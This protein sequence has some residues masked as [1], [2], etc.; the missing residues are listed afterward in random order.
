MLGHLA[1]NILSGCLDNSLLSIYKHVW[2]GFVRV[3]LS[4]PRIQYENADKTW[5]PGQK[6]IMS[7]REPWEVESSWQP[8]NFLMLQTV[9]KYINLEENQDLRSGFFSDFNFREKEAWS[10]VTLNAESNAL[11]SVFQYCLANVSH[12]PQ[13]SYLSILNDFLFL[14]S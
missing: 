5:T 7:W 8:A 14:K 10:Q 12:I 9:V 1:P 11:R 2:R 3:K 6:V 4:Y 13:T